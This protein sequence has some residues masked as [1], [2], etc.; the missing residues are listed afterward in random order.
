MTRLEQLL[1]FILDRAK[2]EGKTDL[3]RFQMFKI[4]YLLQVYSFK[5]A[6]TPFITEATFIR[7]KNGPISINIYNALENLKGAGY[8]KMEIK[9]NEKYGHSKHA[10]TLAKKIPKLDFD[11]GEVIFLDNF[12]SELLPLTQTELKKK[13][14]DTEPMQEIQ[15]KEKDGNILKGAVI[16]FSSISVD[17]DVVDTYSDQ[18]EF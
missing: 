13:A 7:E 5:Y 14:Y 3:S 8:V 9:E 11:Q 18:H 17:P 6:G 12:L 1:L 2:K 10:F 4:P 16:N 15:K